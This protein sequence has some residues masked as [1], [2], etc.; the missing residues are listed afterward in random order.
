MGH[1]S[2]ASGLLPTAKSWWP[3]DEQ[4]TVVSSCLR[5]FYDQ[6]AD[7]VRPLLCTIFFFPGPSGPLKGSGTHGKWTAKECD[8]AFSGN[9]RATWQ[10]GTEHRETCEMV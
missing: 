1:S 10:E 9:W 2:T 6:M 8:A 5:V 4:S 7:F 3:T